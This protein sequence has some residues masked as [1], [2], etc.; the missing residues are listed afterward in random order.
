MYQLL[1]GRIV[2]I[3]HGNAYTLLPIV[4]CGWRQSS[5]VNCITRQINPSSLNECGNKLI[6]ICNSVKVSFI[7]LALQRQWMRDIRQPHYV[8]AHHDHAFCFLI[9]WWLVNVLQQW[10]SANKRA[11]VEVNSLRLLGFVCGVVVHLWREVAGQMDVIASQRY[12]VVVLKVA[13]VLSESSLSGR[14]SNQRWRVLCRG[15]FSIFS[16]N[17]GFCCCYAMFPSWCV[18]FIM[19]GSLAACQTFCK[20]RER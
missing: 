12:I 17:V 15:A 5:S 16:Q 3:W 7:L 4:A 2:T 13:T 11:R 6:T 20:D 9:T 14:K 8:H 18:C 10:F 1:L 19:V